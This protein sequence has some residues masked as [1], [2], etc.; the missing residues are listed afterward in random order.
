MAL[1][2]LLLVL[3]QDRNAATDGILCF[4][5]RR[6][7]RVYLEVYKW[8]QA[9]VHFLGGWQNERAFLVT[10]TLIEKR[11]RRSDERGVG[12]ILVDLRLLAPVVPAKV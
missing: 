7:Q 3:L 8:I 4:A 2:R 9:R 12:E 6:V 5:T 1:T 10:I 11:S